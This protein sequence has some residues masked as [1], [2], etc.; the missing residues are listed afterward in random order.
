MVFGPEAQWV[1]EDLNKRMQV[2][3]SK[4][5]DDAKKMNVAKFDEEQFMKSFQENQLKALA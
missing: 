3:T 4:L 5:K 1:L 2:F